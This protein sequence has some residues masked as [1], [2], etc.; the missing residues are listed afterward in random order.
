MFPV[1]AR[2]TK[3]IA[4]TVLNGEDLNIASSATGRRALAELTLL[5]FQLEGLVKN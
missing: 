2:T 3:T 1:N 4:C 5:P